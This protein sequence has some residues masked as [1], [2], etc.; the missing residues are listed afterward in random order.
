VI[1]AILFMYKALFPAEN[2]AK[3]RATFIQGDPDATLSGDEY[4]RNFACREMETVFEL[5]PPAAVQPN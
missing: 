2:W 1:D 3:T 4:S 5:L